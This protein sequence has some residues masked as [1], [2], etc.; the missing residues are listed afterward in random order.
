VKAK[1]SAK[2]IGASEWARAALRKAISAGEAV[3]IC[4][5]WE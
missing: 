2:A 4:A 1:H 5:P 3:F